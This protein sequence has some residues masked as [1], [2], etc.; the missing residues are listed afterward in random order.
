MSRAVTVSFANLRSRNEYKKSR[1]IYRRVMLSLNAGKIIAV[2]YT[3]KAV[4]K[5][6]PEK[7]RVT[8]FLFV[9]T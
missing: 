6:K 4:T 3:T 7:F 1:P 8:T 2:K 5:R 9:T